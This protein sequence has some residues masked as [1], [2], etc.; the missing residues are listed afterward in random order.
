MSDSSYLL[1]RRKTKHLYLHE[2]NKS[3]ISLRNNRGKG[4]LYYSIDYEPINFIDMARGPLAYSNI[5]QVDTVNASPNSANIIAI[6]DNV[7]YFSSNN[8]NYSDTNVAFIYGSKAYDRV[9]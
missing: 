2:N 3:D 6:T 4:A 9:L 8:I 5:Y 7:G 1:E